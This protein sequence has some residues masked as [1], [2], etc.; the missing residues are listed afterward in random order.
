MAAG[1]AEKDTD[2]TFGSATALQVVLNGKLSCRGNT[3]KGSV[4]A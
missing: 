1:E 3:A 2:V 4:T